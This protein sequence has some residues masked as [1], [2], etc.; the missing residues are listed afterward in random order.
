[1]HD[2]LVNL[3]TKRLPNF[4]NVNA[5]ES[6]FL[7]HIRYT[8]VTY[9]IEYWKANDKHI[10]ILC[11]NNHGS[12]VTGSMF[13]VKQ[14]SCVSF[15]LGGSKFINGIRVIFSGFETLFPTCNDESFASKLLWVWIISP[16]LA[17]KFDEGSFTW[18]SHQSPPL[19]YFLSCNNTTILPQAKPVATSLSSP[20]VVLMELSL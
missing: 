20:S 9:L 6:V 14:H 8:Y 16:W 10:C 2:V 5:T 17:K 12:I 3:F 11:H 19:L 18:T 7:F 13:G 15:F 1:M 4:V